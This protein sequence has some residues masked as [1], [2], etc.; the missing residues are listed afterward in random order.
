MTPAA[1][2]LPE[3]YFSFWKRKVSFLGSD[4]CTVSLSDVFKWTKAKPVRWV[5]RHTDIP[6]S[7]I[8]RRAS[9][10]FP[11]SNVNYLCSHALPWGDVPCGRSESLDSR[12]LICVEAGRTVWWLQRQASGGLHF[13]FWHSLSFQGV[14]CLEWHASVVVVIASLHHSRPAMVHRNGH[15][16]SSLNTGISK[17]L[18]D[19]IP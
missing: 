1:E 8:A 13:E 19:V 5:M 16:F 2:K 11:L 10:F 6:K 14:W 7:Q 4:V 18:F 12:I 3:E 15:T 17:V 9:D